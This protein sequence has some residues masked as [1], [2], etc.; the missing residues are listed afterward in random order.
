MALLKAQQRLNNAEFRWR[1]ADGTVITLL[2]N[3]AVLRDS[4]EGLVFVGILIDVTDRNRLEVAER[5]AEALRAVARLANTAAHEINNPLAV[6]MGHL[7]LLARRFADDPEVGAR[8]DKTL[9]ACRRISEMIAHMGRITR[10]EVYQQSPGLPPIL[11]LRRSSEPPPA[12][13][14]SG[15]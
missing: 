9:D 14:P 4:A 1:R 15:A 10:L 12:E 6:I 2:A 7:G 3:V 5:E 13:D 8:V 11:D